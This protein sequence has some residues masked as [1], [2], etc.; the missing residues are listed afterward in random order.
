[1]CLM[2]LRDKAKGAGT[3]RKV[4]D[5]HIHTA[6]VSKEQLDK[7]ADVLKI[8]AASRKKFK[9]GTLHLVNEKGKK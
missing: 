5:A 7:I 3:H 8:P 6:A 9:A 2:P 4:T 1:M